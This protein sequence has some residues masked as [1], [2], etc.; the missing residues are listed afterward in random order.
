MA[1]GQFLG[2]LGTAAGIR[3]ADIVG[4]GLDAYSDWDRL[5]Q[6]RAY[7]EWITNEQVKRDQW[8]ME[9]YVRDK[10]EQKA[11]RDELLLKSANLSEA[12]AQVNNYLGVP[13]A[14]SR[15]DIIA[16]YLNLK[17]NYSDDVLRLAELSDSQKTAKNMRDLGGAHSN[18]M[19][20]DITRETVDEFAPKL[21]D[22]DLQ[23]K[24]DAM[25][26]AESQMLLDDESRKR[27]QK[28]YTDPYQTG[29]DTMKELLPTSP[30]YRGGQHLT[31]LADLAAK[32]ME[33]GSTAFSD[34][35]SEIEG[36][37]INEF[38]DKFKKSGRLN[39]KTTFT[40]AMEGYGFNQNQIDEFWKQR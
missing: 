17:N 16:D 4:S 11:I 9:N 13:Y 27:I 25:K 7:R 29:F 28:H 39:D 26:L 32:S 37:I 31:S 14:P 33:K 2:T 22:A 18:T 34:S 30:S 6:D 5:R 15:A 23:A 38:P 1:W 21:W 12:V 35:L 3:G 40:K 8:E 24:L 36:R 10:A 19:S 20:R